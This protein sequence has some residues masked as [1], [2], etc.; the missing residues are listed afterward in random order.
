MRSLET[1][2]AAS[3]AQVPFDDVANE[4]ADSVLR[5][6]YSRAGVRMRA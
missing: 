3:E 5:F 2:A 4:D 6:E 1:A